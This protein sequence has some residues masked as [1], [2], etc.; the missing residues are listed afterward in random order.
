M[1]YYCVVKFL[2]IKYAYINKVDKN[3]YIIVGDNLYILNDNEMNN[4]TCYAE[5]VTYITFTVL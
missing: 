4:R 5:M 1:L 2:K 3:I